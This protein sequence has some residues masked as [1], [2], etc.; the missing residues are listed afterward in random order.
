VRPEAEAA[1]RGPRRVSQT[2]GQGH[3]PATSR[4]SGAGRVHIDVQV[5]ACRSRS[6]Q[7][8]YGVSVLLGNASGASVTPRS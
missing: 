2:Q 7:Y 8:G 6:L 4:C 3:E 1:E 5:H